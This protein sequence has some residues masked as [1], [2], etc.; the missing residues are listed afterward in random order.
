MLRSDEILKTAFEKGRAL[1]T[2]ERV[3][4]R[5]AYLHEQKESKDGA[6]ILKNMAK[7]FKEEAVPVRPRHRIQG[8]CSW[9]K[10]CSFDFKCKSYDPRFMKCQNCVLVKEDGVCKKNEL[11]TEA[12][13]ALM[14]KRPTIK[15]ESANE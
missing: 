14:I 15:V 11:H 8:K 7:N 2:S 10:E 6:D 9:F 1:T 12:N 3:E 4:L 13:M 5:E